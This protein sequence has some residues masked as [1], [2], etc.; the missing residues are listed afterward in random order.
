MIKKIIFGAA[1]SV[2]IF[3]TSCSSDNDPVNP[4]DDVI[5][6]GTPEPATSK[7]LNLSS[8]D[9]G[10][11]VMMQTFYWDVEPR[12]EWWKILNDKVAGWADAGVDRI[13]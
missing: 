1:V 3:G 13:W 8:Y 6:V 12:G 4:T 2:L 7:P 5:G 11:G 10:S 9:N